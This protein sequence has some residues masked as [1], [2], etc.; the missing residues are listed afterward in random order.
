MQDI[1]DGKGY[2]GCPVVI[3]RSL[4]VGLKP[5]SLGLIPGDCQLLTFF[6]PLNIKHNI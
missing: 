1:E 3:A 2:S 4:H 5:G 6:L